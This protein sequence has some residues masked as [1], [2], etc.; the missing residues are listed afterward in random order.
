MAPKLEQ[1]G[2]EQRQKKKG[3]GKGRDTKKD[4]NNQDIL[5]LIFLDFV[6]MI[7]GIMVNHH[8]QDFFNVIFLDFVKVNFF[9]HNCPRDPPCLYDLGE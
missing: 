2:L 7:I 5:I 3:Q 6:K 1:M 9:W 4:K 8:N